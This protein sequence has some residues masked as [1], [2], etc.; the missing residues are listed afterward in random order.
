ME[1]DSKLTNR[2]MDVVGARMLDLDRCR[3]VRV[4]SA[5]LL[6]I[7]C[8]LIAVRTTSNETCPSPASTSASKDVDCAT[9]ANGPMHND[10]ELMS[11]LEASDADWDVVFKPWTNDYAT[12][13]GAVQYER[14][15][16][17]CAWRPRD[18]R[19]VRALHYEGD[20]AYAPAIRRWANG[21]EPDEVG[22]LCPADLGDAESL[23]ASLCE[24][25]GS[26]RGS[27]HWS[28]ERVGPFHGTGGYD[29]S[30]VDNLVDVGDLGKHLQSNG[31]KLYVVGTVVR[32]IRE[33]GTPLAFPPVHVHHLHLSNGAKA[34]REHRPI[35]EVHGD[36]ACHTAQGGMDCLIRMLPPN[37]AYELTEPLY[38]DFVLNDVRS[39]GAPS[40]TYYMEL[41]IAW[42]TNYT[43]PAIKMSYANPMQRVGPGVY[44]IPPQAESVL[45]FAHRHR[46]NSVFV[47][48]QQVYHSHQSRAA[49]LWVFSGAN[50]SKDVLGLTA[51]E[52]EAQLA[53]QGTHLPYV[54]SLHQRT[55][56]DVKQHIRQY[57]RKATAEGNRDLTPVCFISKP[58]LEDGK[59]RRSRVL[60]RLD[61]APRKGDVMVIVA[62]NRANPMGTAAG[63]GGARLPSFP[64]HSILRGLFV[65]SAHTDPNASWIDPRLLSP[66]TYYLGDCDSRQDT[67]WQDG[68]FW[69]RGHGMACI[70]DSIPARP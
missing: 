39:R 10:T 43:R 64:Q 36:S 26:E 65:P 3:G 41:A 5:V 29:W 35:I 33:D 22:P 68:C 1:F 66:A 37:T 27:V 69:V 9:H 4:A 48:G 12:S 2:K 62:F 60:C 16:S 21:C 40:L 32:P 57:I 54:P 61:W 56:L 20:D 70:G 42:T 7:G 50:V 47:P 46:L 58:C 19:G 6:V 11:L 25:R 55:N 28:I 51:L 38:G 59:D 45:W 15:R 53:R 17:A 31:G 34:G 49:S 44:G 52:E 23:R 13:I 30:T 18:I 24:L 67:C 63:M 14:L 8:V